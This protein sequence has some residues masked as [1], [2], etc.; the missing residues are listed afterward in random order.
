[1]QYYK[2]DIEIDVKYFGQK[3][4]NDRLFSKLAAIIYPS[5]YVCTF[6]V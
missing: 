3:V 1:M 2:T 6:V 4:D 5:L